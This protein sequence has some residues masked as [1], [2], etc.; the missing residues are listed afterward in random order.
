M[1]SAPGNDIGI[2]DSEPGNQEGVRG[3]VTNRPGMRLRRNEQLD[4]CRFAR[5]RLV[6]IGCEDF[7]ELPIAFRIPQV[8]Q[9]QFR[10]G[11]A[12]SSSAMASA[13]AVPMR[14]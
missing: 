2:V 12:A 8:L 4:A 5:P 11:H 3:S 13:K 1:A 9:G 7:G 14:M 10:G 6:G